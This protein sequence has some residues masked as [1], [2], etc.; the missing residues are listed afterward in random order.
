[1]NTAK[2]LPVSGRCLQ[3]NTGTLFVKYEKT[4]SARPPGIGILIQK[5]FP[6][7]AQLICYLVCFR[8]A[9]AGLKFRTTGSAAQA[10]DFLV[11]YPGE[12]SIATRIFV[13]DSP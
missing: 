6:T 1:M 4:L 13:N 10:G 7:Y 3:K 8:D 5:L 11:V 12:I 2:T 9:E